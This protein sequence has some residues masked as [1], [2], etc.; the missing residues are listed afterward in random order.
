MHDQNLH[1]LNWKKYSLSILRKSI[2]RGLFW[3]E[4]HAPPNWKQIER[5]YILTGIFLLFNL[6]AKKKI[7]LKINIS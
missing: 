1:K 2:T 5:F 3:L 6:F 4:K 7:I